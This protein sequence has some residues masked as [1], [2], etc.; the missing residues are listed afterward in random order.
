MNSLKL[1]STVLIVCWGLAGVASAVIVDLAANDS[2]TATALT[3]QLT[4]FERYDPEPATGTGVFE[5]FLRVQGNGVEKGY[6]TDGVIEFQTKPSPWT[7]SIKLGDMG[8]SDGDIVLLLDTAQDDSSAGGTY[9]SLDVL[10]IYLCDSGDLTGYWSADF[11]A[12]VYDLGDN[13]VKINDEVFQPGNGTGDVRILI[14]K[15]RDW[16]DNKYLYLYCQ[17]GDNGGY[18]ANGSFEEWGTEGAAV[19]EPATA[20]L[21]GA[22]L[23]FAIRSRRSAG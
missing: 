12:P 16:D 3:G 2:G 1:V 4:Y 22:A 17:F 7:H 8:M 23:M 6:N 13:W 10:K 9:L 18:A 11:G 15:G 14:P 21:L 19:P 5:P 20:V